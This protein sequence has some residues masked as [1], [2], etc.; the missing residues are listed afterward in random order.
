M[1]V[2]VQGGKWPEDDAFCYPAIR[3]TGTSAPLRRIPARPGGRLRSA[4]PA[5]RRRRPGLLRPTRLMRCPRRTT[6][7]RSRCVWGEIDLS[8]MGMLGS[9]AECASAAAAAA[10]AAADDVRADVGVAGDRGHRHEAFAGRP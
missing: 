2:S 1:L 3:A 9:F 8:R 10:T 6:A 7:G 5:V 4:G